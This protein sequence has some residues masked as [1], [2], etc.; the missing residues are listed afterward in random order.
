MGTAEMGGPPFQ[1]LEP[2]QASDMGGGQG[3]GFLL[4][5]ELIGQ[6]I[7]GIVVTAHTDQGLFQFLQGDQTF[8]V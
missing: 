6:K 1:G 5:H 4:I 3:D 8:C 2:S 7:Q